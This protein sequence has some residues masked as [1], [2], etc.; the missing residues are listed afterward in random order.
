MVATSLTV[1]AYQDLIDVGWRRSGHYV[2]KP[3]LSRMCC[4][5]YT[6]RLDVDAFVPSKEQKKTLRRLQNYLDGGA[7]SQRYIEASPMPRSKDVTDLQMLFG[8]VLDKIVKL[9]LSNENFQQVDVKVIVSE[10]SQRQRRLLPSSMFLTSPV[11]I[12][13]FHTIKPLMDCSR[14]PSPECVAEHLSDLFN[15]EKESLF[16][17]HLTQELGDKWRAMMKHVTLSQFKGHLNFSLNEAGVLDEQ[18]VR[19]FVEILMPAEEITEMDV[20]ADQ[21]SRSQPNSNASLPMEFRKAVDRQRTFTMTFVAS[22]FTEEEYQIYRKYQMAIHGDPPNKCD[23]DQYEWFLVRSPLRRVRSGDGMAQIERG[24]FHIQY[25]IDGRLVGVSA[26]DLLPRCLSSKYFFYDPDFAPL[27][28]GKISALKE[29]EWTQR[30]HA[31]CPS[32]KYYYMGYYIQSCPKMKYKGEYEPSELLC[33]QSYRWVK[34]TDDIRRRLDAEAYLV[35]SEIPGTECS[36][37]AV[38]GED[39]SSLDS[40]QVIISNRHT[41]FGEY[42]SNIQMTRSLYGLL[43]NWITPSQPRSNKTSLV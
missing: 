20:A 33:P 2:Y 18:L 23:R 14:W 41:T 8:H 43:R 38:F 42:L 32:L 24:S 29:I 1:Q 15:A 25:R 7:L 22:I 12:P 37:N 31:V 34:L 36:R 4:P 19:Q 35:L 30:T 5:L 3:D 16:E 13:L 9:W 27:G 39:R 6:I 40:Q 26:V 28:L 10:P 21:L 11:A 17:G